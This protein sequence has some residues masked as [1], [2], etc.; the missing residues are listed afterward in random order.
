MTNIEI[1]L[2]MLAEASTTEISKQNNPQTL[3]QNI[4]VAES[5]GQVANAAR[6]ELESRLGHTVIS[7]ANASN[8]ISEDNQTNTQLT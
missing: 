3:Q 5:G 8:Y 6:I 7:P 2:N 4:G 1:A